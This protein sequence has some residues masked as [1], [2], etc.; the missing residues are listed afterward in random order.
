M[1]KTHLNFARVNN[2][3]NKAVLYGIGYSQLR[4]Y[5][6]PCRPTWLPRRTL[7]RIWTFCITN[8]KDKWWA[9]YFRI[10]V[11]TVK[12]GTHMHVSPGGIIRLCIYWRWII[13]KYIVFQ[14]TKW[15]SISSSVDSDSAVDKCMC[16]VRGE[17]WSPMWSTE[18]YDTLHVIASIYLVLFR[19]Y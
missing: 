2:C 12:G 18:R 9:L 19:W 15:C 8:L 10:H 5:H 1:C 6:F 13:S 4:K 11:N 7:I 3:A 17:M 16:G 14:S